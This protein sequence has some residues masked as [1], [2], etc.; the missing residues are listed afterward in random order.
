MPESSRRKPDTA[1]LYRPEAQF[2]V[3]AYCTGSSSPVSMRQGRAA[4]R[5]GA[6]VTPPGLQSQPLLPGTQG[7]VAK[8]TP[9]DKGQ[10]RLE[11]NPE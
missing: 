5:R 6:V 10:L 1:A 2:P 4:G 3:S 8:L 7:Q 11:A 9:V